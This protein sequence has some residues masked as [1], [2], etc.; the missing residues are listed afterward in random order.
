MSLAPLQNVAVFAKLTAAKRKALAA[1]LAA[2]L[3]EGWSVE[4]GDGVLLRHAPTDLVFVAVPGGTFAMGLTEA[5]VAAIRRDLAKLPDLDDAIARLRRSALPERSVEVA[6]FLASRAPLTWQEVE[7]LSKKQQSGMYCYVLPRA[8]ARRLASKLG[9]RLCSEA[10]L[11]WVARD[12]GKTTFVLDAVAK[13]G[14]VK[15][16]SDRIP[17]RFGLQ[18]L[19][20]QQ[21]AEDDYH[22]GIKGAPETSAPWMKGKPEGIATGWTL[23]EYVEEDHQKLGLAACLRGSKSQKKAQIRLA[24]DL[25]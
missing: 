15:G 16:M 4:K 12:A 9:F 1:E 8:D 25:A 22:E 3:G 11:Q 21:W 2:H 5:D 23:P 6:P 10:E 20:C 18:G 19:F 17:S 24:L 13:M 14:R 7:R